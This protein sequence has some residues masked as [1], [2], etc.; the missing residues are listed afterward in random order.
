MVFQ[1]VGFVNRVDAAR[2]HSSSFDLA[3]IA[4]PQLLT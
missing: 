3:A 2:P 1:N 4:L